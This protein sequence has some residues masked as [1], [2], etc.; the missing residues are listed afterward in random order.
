MKRKIFK[1]KERSFLLNPK[2]PLPLKKFLR[3]EMA[4]I[5]TGVGEN[6]PNIIGYPTAIQRVYVILK[7]QLKIVLEIS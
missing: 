1:R 7:S 6:H 5:F 3:K 4:L 2:Q